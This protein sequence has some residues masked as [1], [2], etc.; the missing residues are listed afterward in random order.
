[1]DSTSDFISDLYEVEK[2]INFKIY[3]NKKYYLV[4]WL[5]YPISESTWE[6]KE[7]L[8]NLHYLI[9]SFEDEY[10][11]SIDKEMYEIYCKET[12]K[13]SKR[14]NKGKNSKE[15]KINKKFL[16][17]KK[18][19]EFFTNSELKD[20]YFDKLKEHLHLNM[21]KRLSKADKNNLYIDLS[22]CLTLSEE[23]ENSENS[24]K[25]NLDLNVEKI[26]SNQLIIPIIE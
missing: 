4:K 22:S 21:D 11:Y 5:C 19:M 26:N 18:K 8:N 13:R 7:N 24:D 14:R 6:P 17:K 2:I 3:K 16:S 9:N 1:M 23:N 15:F 12:K 10:P 25:S 20:T